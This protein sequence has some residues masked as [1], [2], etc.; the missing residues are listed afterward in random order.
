MEHYES[1]KAAIE[2]AV[3][4]KTKLTAAV[5]GNIVTVTPEGAPAILDVKGAYETGYAEGVKAASD[6]MRDSLKEVPKTGWPKPA[7]ARKAGAEAE[8][9][10]F[11]PVV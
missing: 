9:P 11:V 7:R 3:T 2:A 6:A 8:E 4:G 10:P 1:I 5:G